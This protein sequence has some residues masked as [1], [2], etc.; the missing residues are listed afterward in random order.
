MLAPLGA[1]LGP[2]N[3]PPTHQK[4][5]PN[6]KQRLGAVSLVAPD[7]MDIPSKKHKSLDEASA[8]Q[9]ET[10]RYQTMIYAHCAQQQRVGQMSAFRPW[11][12]P[13]PKSFMHLSYNAAAVAAL[14][15]LPYL[16]QE[17]PVLQHPERV[18]RSTDRER[19]E[20]TYQPNVALAPRKSILSKEREK[21]QREIR[22][23]EREHSRERDRS[24]ERELRERELKQELLQ[25]HQQHQQHLHQHHHQH[26]NTQLHQH[27]HHQHPAM[28][29]VCDIDVL[30]IKQERAATPPDNLSSQ[31][32]SPPPGAEEN[33]GSMD[34]H[35][36]EDMQMEEQE[37][38]I[39]MMSPLIM[40]QPNFAHQEQQQ[41]QQQRRHSLN[42]SANV[43]GSTTSL[44]SNMSARLTVASTTAS[45]QQHLQ[46]QQQQALC[47]NTQQLQ[48]LRSGIDPGQATLIKDC[49]SSLAAAQVSASIFIFKLLR[50]T[51]RMIVW[52]KTKE[53]KSLRYKE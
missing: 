53:L 4:L 20:R 24:R 47:R 7:L 21:E 25:Q 1:A 46:K 31:S 42:T 36:A 2:G 40:C 45:N 32:Q 16:S 43:A 34:R 13:T 26:Q 29:A 38:A 10:M 50:L 19:F 17:P 28:S 30:Q 39:P 11:G 33:S 51:Q 14:S 52:M 3:L 8:Y 12:P 44:I 41:T 15:S 22:D 27:H 23:K 49:S 18:V 6:G 9:L 5:P 35:D 48:G 37:S